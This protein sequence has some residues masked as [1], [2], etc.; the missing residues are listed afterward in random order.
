[1]SRTWRFKFSTSFHKLKKKRA[2]ARATFYAAWKSSSII[3]LGDWP[4][5]IVR[6]FLSANDHGVLERRQNWTFWGFGAFDAIQFDRWRWKDRSPLWTS[7]QL[8]APISSAVARGT[9][10]VKK[11]WSWSLQQSV[12]SYHLRCLFF[13]SLESWILR[14]GTFPRRSFESCLPSTVALSFRHIFSL[15]SFLPRQTKAKWICLWQHCWRCTSFIG[16]YL[17]K[18]L[19]ELSVKFSEFSCSVKMADRL[20]VDVKISNAVSFCFQLQLNSRNTSY[21]VSEN[22]S[23]HFEF[24]SWW[25]SCRKYQNFEPFSAALSG[26][27]FS[28][29]KHMCALRSQLGPHF[30]SFTS[31]FC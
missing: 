18:F 15:S 3:A 23:P 5:T 29:V 28:L 9:L 27:L 20:H 8:F 14:S 16:K 13:F 26:R 21:K 22:S 24:V 31:F 1:M 30:H 2:F 10:K 11:K 4:I 6:I 12:V 25:K 19:L 17:A 7:R